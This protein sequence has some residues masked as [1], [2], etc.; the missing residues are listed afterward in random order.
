MGNSSQPGWQGENSPAAEPGAKLPCTQGQHCQV[1]QR[2]VC[3]H[4]AITFLQ[5]HFFC[6]NRFLWLIFSVSPTNC[7]ESCK[8]GACRE[9]GRQPVC[10]SLGKEGTGFEGQRGGNLNI[11]VS[12]LVPFPGPS[13]LICQRC[14]REARSLSC[15]LF[16]LTSSALCVSHQEWITH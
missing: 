3:L 15:A 6:R 9:G 4:V 14:V 5:R 13:V 11:Q 16:L 8:E 12:L 1:P 10:V 7:C 2:D